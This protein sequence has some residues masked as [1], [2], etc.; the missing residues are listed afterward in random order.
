MYHEVLPLMRDLMEEFGDDSESLWAQCYD[1][2]PYDRIV[3]EDLRGLGYKMLDRRK[4][5]TRE[6]ASVVMKALGKFHAMSVVLKERDKL[7]TIDFKESIHTSGIEHVQSYHNV[8]LITMAEAIKDNWGDEWSSYPNVLRNLVDTTIPKLAED[9]KLDPKGFNVLNHG[10]C[11]RNNIMFKHINDEDVPTGVRFVDFQMCY[12]STYIYDLQYF[13]TSSLTPQV[14]D[15]HLDTLLEDYRKSV[16]LWLTRM[17]RHT[18]DVPTPQKIREDFD[19]SLHLAL[20][21]AATNLTFMIPPKEQRPNFVQFVRQMPRK[22]VKLSTKTYSGPLYRQR[23]E[24]ILKLCK[25]AG[26]I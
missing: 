16:V 4:P 26:V 1:Y 12:Y 3:L 19:K 2:E 8:A 22:A 23:A 20:I 17:G 18:D 6:H 7:N 21:M 25:D 11:W 14:R 15:D 5:V 9:F 10:D 24:Y 13:V